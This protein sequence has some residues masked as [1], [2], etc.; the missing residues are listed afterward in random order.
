MTYLINNEKLISLG[1]LGLLLPL[2]SPEFAVSRCNFS[3][4]STTTS[5]FITSL[6][7]SHLNWLNLSINNEKLMNLG[8]SGLL[9]L[10]TWISVPLIKWSDL[11]LVLLWSLHS[12]LVL[13][14]LWSL[15]FRSVYFSLSLLWFLH[16]QYPRFVSRLV[17]YGLYIFAQILKGYTL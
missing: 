1:V 3:F 15:H 13:W 10:P 4:L 5:T 8:D 2:L 6:V 16:Y 11:V 17:C 7:V 14:L 9:L 12:C